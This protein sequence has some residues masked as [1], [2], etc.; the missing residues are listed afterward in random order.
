MSIVGTGHRLP[1]TFFLALLIGFAPPLRAQRTTTRP[2]ARAYS[3]PTTRAYTPPPPAP[4]SPAAPLPPQDEIKTMKVAPGYRVE[5][6][7][8]EPL[9]HDPI[10]MSIDPDGRLWVCEMRGFMPDLDEM[11]EMKPV[12]TVSVLED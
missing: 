6:V 12:G 7:A 4:L 10:A 3:L 5:C 11:N 2:A 9:V 8:A 1:A